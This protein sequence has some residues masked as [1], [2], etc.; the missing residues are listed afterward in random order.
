[1]TGLGLTVTQMRA[2]HAVYDLAGGEADGRCDM[3]STRCA[4]FGLSPDTAS[5]SYGPPAQHGPLP[6]P[7]PERIR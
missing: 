5:T 4:P 6:I 7:T 3:V 2:L 1:M